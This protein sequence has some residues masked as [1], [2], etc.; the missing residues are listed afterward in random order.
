MWGEFWCLNAW[1]GF[2]DTKTTFASGAVWEEEALGLRHTW[3]G[4]R[5]VSRAELGLQSLSNSRQLQELSSAPRTP[6]CA[7]PDRARHSLC[8]EPF[9]RFEL[10]V[11]KRGGL[12]TTACGLNISLPAFCDIERMS[13]R[14][15]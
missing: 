6:P 1:M 13:V 7:R 5:D 3:Q 10:F 15:T 14:I 2:I 8:T 11:N 9:L 12:A 4:R